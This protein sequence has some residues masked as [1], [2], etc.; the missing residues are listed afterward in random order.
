MIEAAMKF[1]PQALNPSSKGKWIKA[2]FVLPQ[3]YGIDDVDANRPA[4]V[5]PG[6][7]ESDY[8]NVFVNDDGLVEIEAAFGRADFCTIVTGAEPMEVTVVGSLTSGQ[9]FYG[10]DTI[11]ITTNFF[12]YLGTLASRWLQRG[13]GEPDWCSGLD[14]N[15]DSV[16]NLVDLALFNACCIEVIR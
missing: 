16:V 14:I 3:E 12:K 6:Q 5:E 13:C 8:M 4:V 15:Q 7:I 2:H 11:K 10:T 9:Q 1:T